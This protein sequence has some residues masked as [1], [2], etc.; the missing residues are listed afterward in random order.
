MDRAGD[1]GE[2]AQ[3][4]EGKPGFSGEEVLLLEGLKMMGD[5]RDL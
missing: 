2:Q 1:G 3:E 4:V 5:D